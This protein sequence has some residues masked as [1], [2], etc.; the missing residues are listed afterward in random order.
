VQ[1]AVSSGVA[2]RVAWIAAAIVVALLAWW[3]AVH[4]PKTIAIFVIAAFI[5]FGVSPI[6]QRLEQRH[7]SK[8]LAVGIVFFGLLLIVAILIVIVVPLTYEQ[9]QTLAGNLPGYV[10]TTQ[11]WVVGAE[12]SLQRH[13][14]Q[15]NLPANGINIQKIG[16][17]QVTAVVTGLISGVGVIAI[18]TATGFFVAFS[19]IILSIFFLLNDYQIAGAFCSM[20]P[21]KRRETARSLSAEVANLFGSYISGQVIVSALTGLVVALVT[22]LFHFKFW[23]IVGIITAIAYAIPIIGMLIAQLIAI[24]LSIP[25]GW[26]IVIGVQVTM[27]FMARISDNVL[28]PKI[29]GESV[30]VSP[31]VAFFAVFAGGEVFGIPGLILGIP[32][33]ALLKILWRYF[34]AP[35]IQ[36]QYKEPEQLPAPAPAIPLPQEETV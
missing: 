27:F 16:S 21:P 29:M 12:T 7:M 19:A 22:A 3:L 25:Q 35:W 26:G 14:P 11:D 9:M 17:G 4:I 23:L 18:N 15:L 5:A 32:V 31:I 28:V 33:A 36:S 10:S 20:F 13:F 24:P 8:P 6:V 30:G 34:V 1:A 2:R